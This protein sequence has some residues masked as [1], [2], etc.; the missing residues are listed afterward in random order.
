M[1][2][3]G[4][5]IGVFRA[6]ILVETRPLPKW[7]PVL[8]EP[9][10]NDERKPRQSDD[11]EASADAGSV[12]FIR[13]KIAADN[14]SG[15]YQGRVVTRFPPEPNGYLHIGHAK[16]ICLNFGAALENKGTC[17]LRF[18]DTNPTTEDD[19]YVESIQRDVRWLGFDWGEHRYHA[20]DYFEKLHGYA[21]ELI[22]R[23]KAYVEGA[24]EEEIRRLRGTIS[25]PGTPSAD[26]SRSVE[27]N[28]DLFERMR[29]GEFDDGTYVLR[30]KIDLSA[31]NMKMRDP[32]LYRIRKGAH[33]YRTG[34][35]WCIYP[36]YDFAHC[37]SDAIEGITHSICTL[38]FENNRELYDWV[39]DNAGV[40]PPRP[41]QTEFAR[42][43]LTYTVMSKRKLLR[44]V[45]EKLVAGWGRS[46]D[47]HALGHA[48][49]RYSAFGHS[50]LLRR[51]W[52]GT[53]AQRH[54]PCSLRTHHSR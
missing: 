15:K 50:G 41:E 24:S 30:A 9:T 2:A 11:T 21:V 32:L 47:A 8:K 3:S 1:V 23:G 29:K 27:E 46:A 45:N 5:P 12:D 31:T 6:Y 28:L 33:H 51:D 43:N 37:L 36:F 44:L 52:R 22:R 38:E 10:V 39:L 35:S 17:H 20:S 13:A 26:R 48:A 40:E 4:L 49:S 14:A 42:L 19:E 7:S 54:R 34:D 16:S 18:D 25:E 53:H